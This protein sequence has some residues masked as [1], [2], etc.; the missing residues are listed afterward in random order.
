MMTVTL[1]S[2]VLAM[3]SLAVSSC[4]TTLPPPPPAPAITVTKLL[5]FIG[6]DGSDVLVP[7][8]TYEV[9]PGTGLSLELVSSFGLVGGNQTVEAVATTV[10]HILAAPVALYI[11]GE[12]DEHHIILVQP[13]GEGL[14]AVGSGSAVHPSGAAI[15]PL[16]RSVVKQAL[17]E[18]AKTR[19]PRGDVPSTR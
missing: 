2:I 13:T 19:E 12:H 9:K 18:W 5:H 10:G 8:G 15:K 17:A 1:R 16:S 4:A 7:A 6:S 11:P 14:D 3:L